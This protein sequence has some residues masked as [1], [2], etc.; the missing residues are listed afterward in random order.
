MTDF[1]LHGTDALAVNVGQCGSLAHVF[2]FALLE[3][4]L[5]FSDEGQGGECLTPATNS[6]L[7]S[8]VCET[9]RFGMTL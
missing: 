6:Q 4:Q 9:D 1:A 2:C 7:Y 5:V 3:R 8:P